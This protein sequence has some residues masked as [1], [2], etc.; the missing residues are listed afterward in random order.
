VL[1]DKL[2]HGTNRPRG[3]VVDRESPVLLLSLVM[4]VSI[5]FPAARVAERPNGPE[6]DERL[7]F[8]PTVE[9]AL[10]PLAGVGVR[11]PRKPGEEILLPNQ[12]SEV[13]L[14]V[15]R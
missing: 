5:V 8:Y 2:V 12:C 15:P 3:I 4:F 9:S 7:R 11:F 6:T 13:D 14:S 1:V 10:A